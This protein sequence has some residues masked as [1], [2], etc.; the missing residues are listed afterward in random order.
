MLATMP[1]PAFVLCGA[2]MI[3]RII[4]GALATGL[5]FKAE[6]RTARIKLALSV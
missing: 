2:P 1:N 3:I 5:E 6:E 4:T